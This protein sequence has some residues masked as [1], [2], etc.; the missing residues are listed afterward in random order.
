MAGAGGLHVHSDNQ[1]AFASSIC[2][3]IYVEFE[4]LCSELGLILSN[5]L[6]LI[7]AAKVLDHICTLFID[8]IFHLNDIGDE[9]SRRLGKIINLER[10]SKVFTI[11][12]KLLSYK[13]CGTAYQKLQ[14]LRQILTWSFAE[15]MEHFRLGALSD[16]TQFELVKLVKALF[17]DTPLRL[18]NI[19]EIEK[20][21]P[22]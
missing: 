6:K 21:N 22:L 16:F 12:G 14:V 5:H 4:Q 8:A 13:Y 9:E 2:N 15:I 18:A 10:M 17:S 1:F 20:G 19:T 11:D 3:N 7:T